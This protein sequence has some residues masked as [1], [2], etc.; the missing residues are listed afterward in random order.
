MLTVGTFWYYK[1]SLSSA[2]LDTTAAAAQYHANMLLSTM[3]IC[4]SVPCKCAAQYHANMLLNIMQ[5]C[6]LPDLSKHSKL[7]ADSPIPAIAC[8]LV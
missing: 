3:Q 1:M 2:N 7:Q 6:C 4:C 5:I 8:T